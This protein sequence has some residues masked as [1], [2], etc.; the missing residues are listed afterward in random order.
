VVTLDRSGPT[1]KENEE[2]EESAF[3]EIRRWRSSSRLGSTKEKATMTMD[4]DQIKT[5]IRDILKMLDDCHNQFTIGRAYERLDRLTHTMSDHTRGEVEQLQ[6]RQHILAA[7]ISNGGDISLS[8]I[9][10]A[11]PGYE[12]YRLR[13]ALKQ[14]VDDG[15]IIEAPGRGDRRYYG[16]KIAALMPKEESDHA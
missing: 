12:R 16:I 2:N 5:E 3:G 13:Q 4:S 15:L 6:T 9:V 11:M 10:W 7:L 8:E 14:L 1:A